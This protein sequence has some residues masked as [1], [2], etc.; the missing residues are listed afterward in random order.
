M[1][2][3]Y[4]YFIIRIISNNILLFYIIRIISNLNVWPH[5]LNPVRITFAY[6]QRWRL[7]VLADSNGRPDR[8]PDVSGLVGCALD[9]IV[10]LS[11]SGAML[12]GWWSD[13]KQC[14]SRPIDKYKFVHYVDPMLRR[15]PRPIAEGERWIVVHLGGNDVEDISRGVGSPGDRE[16]RVIVAVEMLQASTFY[17]YIIDINI[18]YLLPLQLLLN[19]LQAFHSTVV[20]I[21]LFRRLKVNFMYANEHD[22]LCRFFNDR[23]R[24]MCGDAGAKFFDFYDRFRDATRFV[25]DGVHLTL[26]SK[27]ELYATVFGAC[28]RERASRAGRLVEEQQLEL[29]DLRKTNS[30]LQDE[31]RQCQAD[32]QTLGNELVR[33]QADNDL[34][35]SELAQRCATEEAQLAELRRAKRRR[36]NPARPARQERRQA[37]WAAEE[38]AAHD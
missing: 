16:C 30:S 2:W 27:L 13:E 5:I 31:L 11:Q 20:V 29:S 25:G 28:C 24:T 17:A 6:F 12:I 22:R 35:R 38:R 7:L 8:S 26:A 19:R 9:E 36:G 32:R 10:N 15:L 34:L 23:A 4:V 18:S 37:K 14:R 3:P 21:G 33:S 1:L